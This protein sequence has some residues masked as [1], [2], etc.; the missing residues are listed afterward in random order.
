MENFNSLFHCFTFGI[1]SYSYYI[2][3]LTKNFFIG[4]LTS[5]LSCTLIYD[6]Y[7]TYSENNDT[8]SEENGLLSLRNILKE[9]LFLN[10]QLKLIELLPDS[11]P[12]P[13]SLENLKNCSLLK[14]MKKYPEITFNIVNKE[15]TKEYTKEY[16]AIEE[17]NNKII[18]IIVKDNAWDNE[19]TKNTL[20]VKVL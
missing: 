16:N 8:S 11:L 3:Y 9:K 2:T 12:E 6:I 13:T 5:M 19:I 7:E 10:R 20:I 1:I 14:T 4:A 17:K 15:Y 18:N